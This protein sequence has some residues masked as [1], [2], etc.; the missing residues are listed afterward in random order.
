MHIKWRVMM[1]IWMAMAPVFGLDVYQSFP[2]DRPIPLSLSVGTMMVPDRALND[3]TL[4][5]KNNWGLDFNFNITERACLGFSLG[6]TT[7]M[8]IEQG[9]EYD[10]QITMMGLRGTWFLGYTKG[11]WNPFVGARLANYIITQS[12]ASK[13]LSSR[14]IAINPEIGVLIPIWGHASIELTLIMQFLT[15]PELFHQPEASRLRNVDD[16]QWV[17]STKVYF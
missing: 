8:V 16:R 11:H 9:Q 13:G 6:G 3:L 10:Y 1:M 14:N 15:L 7:R 5:S 17:L 2:D 4:R 12:R